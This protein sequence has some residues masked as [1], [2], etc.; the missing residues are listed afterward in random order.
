MANI[1]YKFDQVLDMLLLEFVRTKTELYKKLTDPKV[2]PLFKQK[3]FE[4]YYEQ[5]AGQARQSG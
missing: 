3:W 4:G 2:S 5:H 1:R